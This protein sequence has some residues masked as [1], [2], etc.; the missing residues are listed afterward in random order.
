V[1]TLEPTA[2]LRW[3]RWIVGITSLVTVLTAPV[4]AATP[5]AATRRR[6][7]WRSTGCRDSASS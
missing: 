3:T 7:T 6:A 4:G 1:S 5:P 2:S